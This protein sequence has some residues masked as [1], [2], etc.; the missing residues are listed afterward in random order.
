M[1]PIML[2]LVLAGL[3]ASVYLAGHGPTV[4]DSS[5][6]EEYCDVLDV[7]VCGAGGS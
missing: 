6:L 2:A 4:R 5:L 7:A 3:G 1:H